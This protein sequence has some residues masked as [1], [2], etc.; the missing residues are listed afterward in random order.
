MRSTAGYCT[1]T[2]P[3]P[4]APLGGAL[5]AGGAL[6]AEG[7]AGTAVGGLLGALVAGAGAGF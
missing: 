6:G 2:G 4:L 3:P 5:L 1:I 7:A